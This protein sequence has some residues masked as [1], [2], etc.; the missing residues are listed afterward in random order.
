[1]QIHL[2]HVS[3]FLGN[4][5]FQVW[6]FHPQLWEIGRIGVCHFFFVQHP[7]GTIS[8]PFVKFNLIHG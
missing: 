2:R 3:H 8:K 5:P 7:I 4:S 1:M 6:K